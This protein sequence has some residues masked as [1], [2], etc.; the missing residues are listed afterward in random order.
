MTQ[1]RLAMA[2]GVSRGYIAMIELGGANP[3]LDVAARI[4]TALGLEIELA[5]RA[6]I[7]LGDRRQRDAV[8]ARCSGYVHRRLRSSGWQTAREVE[9]VHARSHG[10]IDLL[11]FDPRTGILLVIEIKTWLDDLGT[12]ERQ[13]GWYERSAVTIARSLGW[14]P[15][16]TAGW[17][18]VLASGEIDEFL[19]A[20][21]EVIDAGFPIRARAM[22]GTVAGAGIEVGRGLALIDPMSRRRDWLMRSRLDGR[23]SAPPYIDYADAADRFRQAAPGRREQPRCCQ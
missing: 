3:T 9:V 2:V 21:R 12:V 19:R 22:A 6:P 20:N 5:A 13:L 4:G 16:W 17:L 23:R 18:L 14:R 7:V 15:R 1:K 8:H 11:A 10:W